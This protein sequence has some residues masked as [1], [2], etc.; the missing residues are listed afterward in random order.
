M[1]TLGVLVV[2][3]LSLCMTQAVYGARDIDMSEVEVLA[4]LPVKEIIHNVLCRNSNTE[5]TGRR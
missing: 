1:R 4:K 3:F 5:P 2:L